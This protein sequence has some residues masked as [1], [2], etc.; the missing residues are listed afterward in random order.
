MKSYE[1]P[2]GANFNFQVCPIGENLF[3]TLDENSLGLSDLIHKSISSCDVD[4]RGQLI[5]NIVICGGGSLIPGLIDRL[6]IDLSKHYSPSKLR[7]SLLGS[8]YEK[9]FTSWVGGSVLSSLGTFQQMWVTTKD[10]EEHGANLAAI[11]FL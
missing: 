10:Y 5:S 8:G 2:D 9:K 3:L 11:K 4:L 7:F 6:S 1:F